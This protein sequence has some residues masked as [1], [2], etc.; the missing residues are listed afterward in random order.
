MYKRQIKAMNAEGCP[1]KGC[2]Y[3]GLMLTPD[4]P[5]EMCIRDRATSTRC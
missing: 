4:G 2:L 1:F 5:K 3:F